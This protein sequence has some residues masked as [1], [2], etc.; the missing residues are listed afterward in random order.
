M[1]R[2]MFVLPTEAVPV[3]QAACARA[4]VAGER[5][6]TVQ[7]LERGTDVADPEGWLDR[8]AEET[9]AALRARGEATAADLTREVP[10]L[11]TKIVVDEDKKWGGAIGVSTRV[12]FLLATQGR[13]VRGRPGGS[14]ISTQYRWAPVDAWFGTDIDALP[15]EPARV[16]LARRWLRRFGPATVADL[17]WWTGWTLTVT[18]HAL[19]ALDVVEVDPGRRGGDRARRRPRTRSP[20]RSRGSPSSL[21]WTRRSWAGSAVTGTSAR[22]GSDCSTATAT[23]ARASGSTAGSWAAGRSAPT[24]RSSCSCSGTSVRRPAPQSDTRPSA[25]AHGSAMSAFN[26]PLPHPPGAR[27]HNLGAP[28]GAPRSLLSVR[29]ELTA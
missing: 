11:A 3:V 2:T 14:W 12:L 29:R 19:E 7:L 27:T 13:I 23:P 5:R 9:L 20:S 4:L 17:K 6:R 1:R 8:V 26:P 21:P 28:L 10:D 16:E 15:E 18:R 24:A 22:T 25:S